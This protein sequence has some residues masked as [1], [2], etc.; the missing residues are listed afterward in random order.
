VEVA[1]QRVGEDWQISVSDNG[2]GI[3]EKYIRK[4]FLLGVDGRVHQNASKIPGNGY[5]LHICKK[6]VSG[7]GGRIWMKSRYG[8]GTTFFFTLP[9]A[10][11]AS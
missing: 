4:L 10:P 3:E 1:A 11:P 6:I 5:G 2:S 8:Q 7:H 9:A